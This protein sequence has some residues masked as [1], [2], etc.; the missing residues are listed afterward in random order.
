MKNKILILF[1]CAF[2]SIGLGQNIKLK[3]EK[4]KLSEV[5][6]MTGNETPQGLSLLG[7]GKIIRKSSH[8]DLNSLTYKEKN[9]I[10]KTAK[11]F[12][13]FKIFVDFDGIVDV[14]D[15][16]GKNVSKEILLFFPVFTMEK[17]E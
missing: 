16:D 2:S 5:E 1:L 6:I 12:K 8:T 9:K 3:K 15:K 7:K 10:R 4:C 17:R 13:S 11:K 14:K